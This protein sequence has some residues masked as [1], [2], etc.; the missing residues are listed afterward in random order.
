MSGKADSVLYYDPFNWQN[1]F[2]M[3]TINA[4]LMNYGEAKIS[5]DRA[6]EL[7]PNYT[8][9]YFNRANV[10]FELAEHQFSIEESTPQITISMGGATNTTAEPEKRIP[11]FSGVLKDYD[12][13]VQLDYNMSFAYYN[14]GN[15]KNRTRDFEGAVQDYTIA[16]AI[17]PNF[18]EAFYNRAITLIYLKNTKDA[19][20]DLSRAGELGVQEAYSVIKRYCNK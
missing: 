14:R 18:A 1:Y 10:N 12:R 16:V 8:E 15:I 17:D 11:D 5:F 2:W 3:G 20:L 19:C 6:I 4:M 9:A 13:V 7:N